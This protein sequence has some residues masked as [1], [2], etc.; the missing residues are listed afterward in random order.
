MAERVCECGFAES[1]GGRKLRTVFPTRGAAE[2]REEKEQGQKLPTSRKLPLGT[3]VRRRMKSGKGEKK[4]K[5]GRR[6]DGES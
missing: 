6:N 3:T 5:H 1:G 2:R 4:S